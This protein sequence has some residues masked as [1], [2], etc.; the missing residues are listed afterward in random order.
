MKILVIDDVLENRILI[1]KILKIGSYT[2]VTTFGSAAELFEYLGVN[3]PAQAKPQVDLILM[4]IMMPEM[5]GITATGRLK[6]ISGFE[7][8]IIIMVTA[9][10]DSKSLENSF[11]AGAFDYIR[12]PIDKTEILTRV[13]SALRLKSEMDQRK[14]REKE[15]VEAQEKLQ[16]VN[17][18]LQ[19]LS[20]H[21]GLTGVKNRRLF[22]TS[23]STEWRRTPRE[24]EFI[25]LILLDIDDFKNYNDTYGH[26]AGDQCLQKVA[27]VLNNALH[28]TG[29]GL[30]RYGGE[31]FAAILPN[32][33]SEGALYV[34]E[35]LRK[36]VEDLYIEHKTSRLS[37]HVTIS[38]G[39]STL[40]FD[41]TVTP[42]DLIKLADKA[43][44]D[45]KKAGR[46]CV[47]FFTPEWSDAKI[48]EG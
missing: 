44:Y 31:E 13:R 17:L 26:Q 19:R 43:L 46:N 10:T 39:V 33:N 32:T 18:E 12:K 42:A 15:L 40:P 5:D 7:D 37:N 48:L 11:N 2:D 6:A 14:Q 1:Q 8:V 38:V 41:K 45:A 23:L 22:D 36:K 9:N 28:R 47:R 29:D 3:N 16:E 34:A 4:D 27:Q 21:D 30:F 20:T 24:S 25:S 35:I